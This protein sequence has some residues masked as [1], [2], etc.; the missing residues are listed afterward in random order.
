MYYDKPETFFA[1]IVATTTKAKTEPF[2]VVSTS[3]VQAEVIHKHCQVDCPDAA[4][5]KY[6]LDSLA[7]DCMDLNDVNKA[8][9]N[10]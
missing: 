5:K 1:T 3:R 7:A 8:W 2:V 9:A 10:V 6:N 4:I